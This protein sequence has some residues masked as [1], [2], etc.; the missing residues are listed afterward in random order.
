MPV[1][2]TM[3]ATTLASTSAEEAESGPLTDNVRLLCAPV[4]ESPDW[5]CPVQKC[6]VTSP[7]SLR[8][9]KMFLELPAAERCDRP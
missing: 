1:A 8:M 5:E 4:E 9:C 6:Q 3:L 2:G 7:H